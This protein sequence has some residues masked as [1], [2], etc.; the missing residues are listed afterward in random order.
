VTG[1]GRRC[2]RL[3]AVALGLVAALGVAGWSCITFRMPGQNID[4]P[5]ALPAG[6]ANERTA[7]LRRHVATL[8]GEIGERNIIDREAAL[9]AAAGYVARELEASGHAVTWEDF[10]VS[11]TERAHRGPEGISLVTGAPL[12]KR[13][14]NVVAEVRGAARQDEIVVVGAHYDS[15]VGTPG[16]DDNASGV[17]ALLELAR[18]FPPVS[19][20]RRTLRFV[21]F[22]N[23]ESPFFRTDRMGSAVSASR[24]KAR[25]ERVVAM[26]SLET[27]GYYTKA[28]GSQRFPA[29]F[30][31]LYPS[32]GD[33]VMF[34][35]AESAS[36]LLKRTVRAFRAAATIPSEGGAAPPR[37]A[38]GIDFSDHAPFLAAGYPAVMV[39][40]TAF[41]R[42]GHYHLPSDVPATLDYER[43]TRVTVGLEAVVKDLAND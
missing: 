21:A 40:D 32:T 26:L 43:L 4:G 37:L 6:E 34:T 39:T 20:P 29:P 28:P 27:L 36:A 13:A 5:L 24:A 18:R 17:A 15:V 10:A 16:A 1:R 22:T 23:E 3:V 35:T 2:A 30:S 11:V 41:L 33:F 25:G 8:A 42:N 7:R 14:R 31:A 12:I 9:E 38:A 19:A